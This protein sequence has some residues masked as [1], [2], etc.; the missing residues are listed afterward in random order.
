[1][2]ASVV[3]FN[4]AREEIGR[5]SVNLA[6]ATIKMKLVTSTFNPDVDVHDYVNDITNEL[7]GNGYS[8]KTLTGKAWTP[9][10]AADRCRLS[11][12]DV[13]FVAAGGSIVARRAIMYVDTGNQATSLLLLAILLDDTPADKVATDGQTLRVACPAT[14]WLEI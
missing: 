13:D 10:A 14:G 8:E 6:T 3:V 12:A 1:M 11:S 2:A 4:K 7:S 5:G 9:N